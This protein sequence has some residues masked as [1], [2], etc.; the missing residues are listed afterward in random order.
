MASVTL[1]CVADISG[2]EQNGNDNPGWWIYP[3]GYTAAEAL[4]DSSDSSYILQGSP[5]CEERLQT[6]SDGT[7]NVATSVTINCRCETGSSK[8]TGGVTFQVFQSDGATA[9][10]A[11][12][13]TT[14]L[15]TSWAAYALTPSLSGSQTL[16]AWTNAELW[17]SS[18]NSYSGVS[19]ASV[20]LTYSQ[21]SD[22]SDDSGTFGSG[23]MSTMDAGALVVVDMD[24]ESVY[25][26]YRLRPEIWL[27]ER[28]LILPFRWA[29]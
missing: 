28:R 10:T 23:G 15:T 2:S 27:P 26:G 3:T 8:H 5:T 24:R 29:A 11:S 21:T 25:I 6:P 7:F 1:Q 20:T 22:D 18:S 17:I 14:S 13:T 16:T 12:A 4:S 19:Q 9:L